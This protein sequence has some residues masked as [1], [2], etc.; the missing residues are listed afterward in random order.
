M[1]AFRKV[2]LCGSTK[3]MKEYEE[4]NSRLT[5][6]GALVYS[7]AIDPHNSD[8]EVTEQEKI[9]LDLVHLG[10]ILHSDSIFVLDVNEYIGDSTKREILW[11]HMCDVEVEYLSDYLEELI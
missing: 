10:K 6:E 9:I 8:K 11:A 1:Y 2:T 5:L 4:H 3:F 7:V